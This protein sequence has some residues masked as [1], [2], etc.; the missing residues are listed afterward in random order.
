M[1]NALLLMTVSL[2]VASGPI[3]Q[4]DNTT[5]DSTR[6]EVDFK[7]QDNSTLAVIFYNGQTVTGT[8]KT[9]FAHTIVFRV[10]NPDFTTRENVT[11]LMIDHCRNS[12]TGQVEDSVAGKLQFQYSEMEDLFFATI[13]KHITI[14]QE[15]GTDHFACTQ[16]VSISVDG[17][18]LTTVDAKSSEFDLDMS[19]P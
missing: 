5:Y 12:I 16:S 4:A 17:K 7:S 9:S 10:S 8:L 11:G 6:H 1:K 3:V 2:L 13:A 15:R 18:A 19:A 14:A